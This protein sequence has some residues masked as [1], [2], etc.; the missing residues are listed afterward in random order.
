MP[1]SEIC[2]G[3]H[4]SRH[5]QVKTGSGTIKT[6]DLRGKGNDSR[7]AVD[8]FPLVLLILLI[9]KILHILESFKI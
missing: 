3:E 5:K 6:D 2:S 1:V 7:H 4:S 8:V 9:P